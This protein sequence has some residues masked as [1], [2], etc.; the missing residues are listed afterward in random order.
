MAVSKRRAIAIQ[1]YRDKFAYITVRVTAAEK[2][3]IFDHANT[4]G[5]SVNSF[6]RRAASEQIREDLKTSLG[7]GEPS[8][9]DESNGSSGSEIECFIT[10]NSN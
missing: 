6:M 2:K 5:E 1:R 10:I 3:A 7:R 9:C 4:A 8:A